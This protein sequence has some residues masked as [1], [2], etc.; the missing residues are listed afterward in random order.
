MRQHDILMPKKDMEHGA[1]YKGKCRNASVARWNAEKERF[2]YTRTKFSFVFTESIKH[3]EDF[4]LEP[5][6]DCF[7]PEEKLNLVEYEIEFKE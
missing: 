2:Y 6:I 7:N 3:E 4:P 1:Y 5:G